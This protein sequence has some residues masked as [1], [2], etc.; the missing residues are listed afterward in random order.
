M[1]KGLYI[2]LV[3]LLLVSC[4]DFQK[5]LKSEDS[6][7]KFKMGIELFEAEKYIKTNK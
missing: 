7:E 2:L 5:V 4:S 1:K 3:T 6:A